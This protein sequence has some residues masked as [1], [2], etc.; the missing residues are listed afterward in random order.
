MRE[1]GRALRVGFLVVNKGERQRSPV[2]SVFTYKAFIYETDVS[3]FYG[4]IKK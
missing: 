2:G 4:G 1:R 3:I